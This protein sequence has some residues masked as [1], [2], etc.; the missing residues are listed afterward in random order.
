MRYAGQNYELSVAMPAGAVDAAS[1]AELA[2]GFAQA[3]LQRFGFV[4]EGETVQ[5][6]TL[7]SEA[8]GIVAKAEFNRLPDA[9]P[10]ASAARVDARECG[11]PRPAASSSARSTPERA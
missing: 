9:G 3:H 11:C 6:V 5:I 1:F 10:D 8:A 4:A 2:E 7:R